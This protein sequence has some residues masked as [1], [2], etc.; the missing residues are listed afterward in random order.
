MEFALRVNY[1]KHR[2]F[3]STRVFFAR[4]SQQVGPQSKLGETISCKAE[5][6]AF[7]VGLAKD[8]RER[9]K[10]VQLHFYFYA[11]KNFS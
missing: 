10:V 8:L 2:V 6:V 5:E 4:G 9:Q 3:F 1:L 7:G 11:E